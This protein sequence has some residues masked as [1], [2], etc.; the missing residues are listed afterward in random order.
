[1]E[2]R[3]TLLDPWVDF[4]FVQEV[5][6]WSRSTI[7]RKIN[8]GEIPS[9]IHIST[10]RRAFKRSWIIDLMHDIEESQ[11]TQYAEAES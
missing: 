9:P 4:K 3:E 2:S 10:N 11:G 8:T 5:T 7:Y 6:T 1:M